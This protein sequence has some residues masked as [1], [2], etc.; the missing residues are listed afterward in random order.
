M[1]FLFITKKKRAACQLPVFNSIKL[2]ILYLTTL[3]FLIAAN[4]FSD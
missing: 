2:N 1:K 4:P 3:S